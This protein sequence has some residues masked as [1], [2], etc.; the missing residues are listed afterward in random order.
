MPM[1]LLLLLP[2]PGVMLPSRLG[3]AVVFSLAFFAFWLLTLA[4]NFTSV[5][6]R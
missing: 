2:N 3:D 5:Y 4:S 1:C 6:C